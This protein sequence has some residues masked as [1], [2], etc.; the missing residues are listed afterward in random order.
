MD[1]TQTGISVFVFLLSILFFLSLQSLR[2][3]LRARARVVYVCVCAA[4]CAARVEKIKLH[5][6]GAHTEWAMAEVRAMQRD[7]RQMP[8][9]RVQLLLLGAAGDTAEWIPFESD[10]LAPSGKRAGVMMHPYACVRFAHGALPA[11][12]PLPPPPPPPPPR[13]AAAAAAAAAAPPPIVPHV[14]RTYRYVADSLH[15]WHY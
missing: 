3:L 11:W 6:L 10:R 2:L 13:A 1:P 15:M 4:L 14:R 5:Q 7:V 12:L 9:V 8:W